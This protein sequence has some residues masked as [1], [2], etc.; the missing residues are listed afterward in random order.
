MIDLLREL[1]GLRT[2][3]PPSLLPAVMSEL[4][5]SDSYAPLESALGTVLVAFGA[6]G[7]TLVVRAAEEAELVA[8]YPA[9]F[10]RPLRRVAA[11]PGEL[12]R[13][14]RFDLRG[15]T[16]FERAVLTTT[17]TIPAGEVRPYSWVAREIG[18]PRAVR[19]VGSALGRNPVPLL[20]PCHRVVRS[21]GHIGEYG[22]GGPAAKRAVL[23]AE[24]LDTAWLEDL[25]RRGGRYLG[26]D[27][28]HVFCLPSCR[29]ARRITDRHRVLLASPAA[30]SAAGF[31]PCKVCRPVP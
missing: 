3:A 20:I 14:P 22:L 10:G 27:T 21:D 13:R 18:R 9:R 1:R 28:T 15:L 31:R 4:G 29:H 2:T 19:A 5:L 8:G 7:V 26:S 17:A 16:D 11:V 30:A 24:G 12:R 6:K 25:A 23:A